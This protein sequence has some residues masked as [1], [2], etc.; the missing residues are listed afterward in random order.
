MPESYPYYPNHKQLLYYLRS[1]AQQFGVYDHVEC[2]LAVEKLWP[3]NDKEE[4][5]N[6]ELSNGEHRQYR[7]VI[8]ANGRLGKSVTPQHSGCF[9]GESFHSNDY[10]TGDQLRYK[11]V[12]IVG[13]GNSGCDIA[14]DSVYFG[15]KTFLSMRRPY[16]FIPKFIDGMPYLEWITEKANT[17]ES[18]DSF[19]KYARRIFKQS[20]YDPTDFGLPEPDYSIDQT[21][22]SIGTSD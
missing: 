1:F 17:F 16:H 7:T 3:G 19:Y 10:R 5:W 13:A 6:I 2:N 12:L 8:I 20:G 22:L 15:A 4:Y 21:H 18:V 9:S 14:T 11:R